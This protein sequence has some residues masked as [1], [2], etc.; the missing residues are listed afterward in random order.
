[1]T[2]LVRILCNGGAVFKMRH[3]TELFHHS[4]YLKWPCK[5]ILYKDAPWC[6][7]QIPN[8]TLQPPLLRRLNQSAHY[9]ITNVWG[10][11]WLKMVTMVVSQPCWWKMKRRTNGA[12]QGSTLWSLVLSWSLC[13]WNKQALNSLPGFRDGWPITSYIVCINIQYVHM[14]VP[15]DNS[16]WVLYTLMT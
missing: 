15:M 7:G 3:Y 16:D 4:G 5:Y 10:V 9:C 12:A 6:L 11:L 13:I 14:H 1:M 8:L 2:T